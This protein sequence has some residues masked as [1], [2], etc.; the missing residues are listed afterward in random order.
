[1]SK[2]E[3]EGGASG[4]KEGRSFCLLHGGGNH[5]QREDGASSS[6]NGS[7]SSG[8][9]YLCPRNSGG[10][11]LYEKS[12]IHVG[13]LSQNL[14]WCAFPHLF[15]H[16]KEGRGRI[17][18]TEEGEEEKK[19]ALLIK[20]PF[21]AIGL[22]PLH[23]SLSLFFFGTWDNRRS[24]EHLLGRGWKKRWEAWTLLLRWS[25]QEAEKEE[26]KSYAVNNLEYTTSFPKRNHHHLLH[27]LLLLL[28]LFSSW[29]HS[30]LPRRERESTTM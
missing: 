4:R 13:V 28:L 26:E 6:R 17:R 19:K 18:S 23:T 2:R 21:S 20:D 27:L 24:F 10:K 3:G 9:H 5:R 29:L 11:K 14:F 15:P 30:H 22:L 16:G 7:A 1:M 8:R 12:I 25:E